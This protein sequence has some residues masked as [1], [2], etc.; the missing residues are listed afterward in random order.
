[1]PKY[2]A[3]IR[4]IFIALLFF[5]VTGATWFSGCHRLT[6]MEQPGIEP[7]ERFDIYWSTK[8]YHMHV[9]TD[10]IEFKENGEMSAVVRKVPPTIDFFIIPGDEITIKDNC[11]IVEHPVEIPADE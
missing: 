7:S 4:G 5:V 3:D 8:F 10:K 2:P 11:V 6:P 1:M 9:C